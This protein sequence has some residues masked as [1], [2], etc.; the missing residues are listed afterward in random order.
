MSRCGSPFRITPSLPKVKTVRVAR[1]SS[2]P[3][4]PPATNASLSRLSIVGSVTNQQQQQPDQRQRSHSTAIISS[5]RTVTTA[6][7]Q[8]LLLTELKSRK[9]SLPKIDILNSSRTSQAEYKTERLPVI[10][11]EVI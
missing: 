5:R 4:L 8:T 1:N 2:L 3:A 9:Q 6:A 11:P 10:T 7:S